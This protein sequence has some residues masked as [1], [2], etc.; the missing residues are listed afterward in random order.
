[1]SSAF[2]VVA[3]DGAFPLLFLLLLGLFGLVAAAAASLLHLLE[4][5]EQLLLL[6]LGHAL[7]ELGSREQQGHK[8]RTASKNDSSCVSANKKRN[9]AC[10]YGLSTLHSADGHNP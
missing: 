10:A 8:I 6:L 2:L 4:L 7:Q 3:R 5:L 1:M 9:C